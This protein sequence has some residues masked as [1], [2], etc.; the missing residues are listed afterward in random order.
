[1]AFWPRIFAINRSL[2]I[3]TMYAVN[4]APCRRVA[5]SL[6]FKTSVSQY[7]PLVSDADLPREVDSGV[8]RAE[9]HSKS[10]P[11]LAAVPATRRW[12]R[13]CA[14]GGMA[15]GQQCQSTRL[16]LRAGRLIVTRTRGRPSPGASSGPSARNRAGRRGG[17]HAPERAPGGAGRDSRLARPSAAGS[18]S[19][20]PLPTRCPPAGGCAATTCLPRCPPLCPPPGRPPPR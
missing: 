6:V 16:R 15:R 20:L 17:A 10:S 13:P 7:C 3:H 5:F 14:R 9:D 1:M 11:R 8:K 18:P 12:P 4:S 2:V 19:S